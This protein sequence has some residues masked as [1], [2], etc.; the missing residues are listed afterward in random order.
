MPA[1]LC[2]NNVPRDHSGNALDAAAPEEEEAEEAPAAAAVDGGGGGIL[3]E[4][5]PSGAGALRTTVPLRI[6]MP[7]ISRLHG[8]PL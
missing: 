3:P 2:V 6:R 5:C 1:F 4:D 8:L 7:V